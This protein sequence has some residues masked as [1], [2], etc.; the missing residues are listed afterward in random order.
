MMYFLDEMITRCVSLLKKKKKFFTRNKDATW[1]LSIS[2]DS[3]IAILLVIRFG[4][5]YKLFR[6]LANPASTFY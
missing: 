6:S 1:F 2:F 4:K 3:K 5:I